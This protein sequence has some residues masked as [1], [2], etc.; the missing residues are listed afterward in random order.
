MKYVVSNTKIQQMYMMQQITYST[1]PDPLS[2]QVQVRASHLYGPY[3]R[4]DPASRNHIPQ[5]RYRQHL[6]PMS[7]PPRIPLHHERP[8][9]HPHK[10]RFRSRQQRAREEHD[11]CEKVSVDMFC[12]EPLRQRHTLDQPHTKTARSPGRGE[13]KGKERRGKKRT[14]TGCT[15]DT[16]FLDGAGWYLGA[17]SC[18]IEPVPRRKASETLDAIDTRGW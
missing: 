17:A 3:T 8:Y 4:L 7:P 14:N 10:S 15:T 18:T 16:S 5:I 2:F 12:L 1:A 6:P 13:E 9:P 11:R